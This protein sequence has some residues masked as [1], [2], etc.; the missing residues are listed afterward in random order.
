MSCDGRRGSSFWI[1]IRGR[2]HAKNVFSWSKNAKWNITRWN[3]NGNRWVSSRKNAIRCF[4]IENRWSVI[5]PSI[6]DPFATVSFRFAAKD[7]ART[8]R[9]LDYYQGDDNIHLRILHDVLMTYN[10]FNFDLGSSLVPCW[11]K[12]SAL[13]LFRLCS[14]NEWFVEPNFDHHGTRSRCVLVFCWSNVANGQ[15][16]GRSLSQL[17]EF[18]GRKFSSRS[19]THQTATV[20][21]AHVTSVHRCWT[22]E[23]FRYEERSA[24]F[25]SNFFLVPVDNNANNMY[26]FFR[27]ILIC[28]KREFPFDDV[29]YLWE[30][31]LKGRWNREASIDTR[32]SSI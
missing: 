9:N 30:V 22:S 17:I 6:I 23:I 15:W 8:D 14:R 29:M 28:F 32:N 13:F 1:I 12:L 4:E 16:I 20:Q 26:F 7:V 27:W 5:R 18:L 24:I 11:S 3:Y 2:R 19:V 31:K 10:M 21:S 25:S